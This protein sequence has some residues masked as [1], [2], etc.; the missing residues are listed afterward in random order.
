MQVSAQSWPGLAPR[1]DDRYRIA[2]AADG[3]IWLLRTPHPDPATALAGHRR[4]ADTA[5]RVA[6]AARWGHQGST[7]IR[8]EPVAD[9]SHHPIPATHPAA[10]ARP[11]GPHTTPLPDAGALLDEAFGHEPG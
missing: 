5:R 6:G 1:D 11:T 9:P 3:G 4:S 10:P 8:D 2:A 7:R